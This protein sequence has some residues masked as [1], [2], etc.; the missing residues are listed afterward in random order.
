ML[1]NYYTTIT[2]RPS[3]TAK[4]NSSN[5]HTSGGLSKKNRNIVLGCC[6][7]IGIPV[8]LVIALF[9]YVTCIRSKKVDF[10][11]SDGKVVST[12]K[13]NKFKLFWYFL[14]GKSTNSINNT[15]DDAHS[16]TF[17]EK[18]HGVMPG[19]NDNTII[20]D[21][22]SSMMSNNNS[23]V[24]S[25]LSANHNYQSFFDEGPFDSN[26]QYYNFTHAREQSPDDI[27]G[28]ENGSAYSSSSGSHGNSH[29]PNVLN[30]ANPDQ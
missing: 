16:D 19:R 27:F 29:S 8:F 4:A 14:M 1:S 21:N 7:G 3:A 24:D 20:D 18:N 9:I 26:E 6:L 2:M 13:M 11:D 17:N 12:Y 30:I 28:F 23:V 5:K 25:P 22:S 10:I 15:A